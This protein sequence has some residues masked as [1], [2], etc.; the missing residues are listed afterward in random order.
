[1][2]DRDV[3]RQIEEV[4]LKVDPASMLETKLEK[5][6]PKWYFNLIVALTELYDTAH[7]AAL[8]DLDK[9]K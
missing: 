5:S 6:I 2:R 4:L 7:A 9:L 1:M 8:H 3:H